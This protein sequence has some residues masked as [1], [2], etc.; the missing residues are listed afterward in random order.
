MKK[1]I[2]THYSQQHYY[3]QPNQPPKLRPS[4]T[5]QPRTGRIKLNPKHLHPRPHQRL[6]GRNVSPECTRHPC[7][8]RK[9]RRA[10]HQR[11]ADSRHSNRIPRCHSGPR[12]IRSYPRTHRTRHLHRRGQ[13][14]PERATHPCTNGKSTRTRLLHNRGRQRPHPISESSRSTNTTATSQHSPNSASQQHRQA[15]STT[16]TT[17][18]SRAHMAAFVDRTTNSTSSVKK[19]T[20]TMIKPAH[21]HGK[22]APEPIPPVID[23]QAQRI[24]KPSTLSINSG[25]Q[26]GAKELIQDNESICNRPKPKRKTWRKTTTSTISHRH[27]DCR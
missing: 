10:R 3:S 4:P 9:S 8:S 22:N 16:Q 21:V 6:P 19:V 1:H 11:Q 14:P 18:V 2:T 25:K 24:S 27:M 26:L 20:S 7:A 15:A 17:I 12:R 5:Y 13:I 23:D